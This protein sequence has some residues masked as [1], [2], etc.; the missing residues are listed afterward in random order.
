[1]TRKITETAVQNQLGDIIDRAV[2]RS[3]RFLVDRTPPAWLER[4]WE[5]AKQKG[6]DKLTPAE[7]DAEIAAAQCQRDR[8]RGVSAPEA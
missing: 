7:I 4:S 5:G 2:T 8:R 3:E 1:M 6:L